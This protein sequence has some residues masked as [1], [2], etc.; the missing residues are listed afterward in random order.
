MPSDSIGYEAAIQ[1]FDEALT[2][3]GGAYGKPYSDVVEGLRYT[4]R[5]LLQERQDLLERLAA[6]EN[7]LRTR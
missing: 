2:F 4:V 1:K 5:A 3:T 6:I 7:L